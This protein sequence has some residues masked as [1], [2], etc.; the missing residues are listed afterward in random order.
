MTFKQ[1]LEWQKDKWWNNQTEALDS[2]YHTGVSAER[3]RVR[4]AVEQSRPAIEQTRND[5][6][7][8]KMCDEILTLIN[9]TGDDK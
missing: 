9:F 2:A 1:W 8:N 5:C 4:F 6:I 7:W 3:E